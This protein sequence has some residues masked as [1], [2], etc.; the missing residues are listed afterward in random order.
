VKGTCILCKALVSITLNSTC[1]SE[2]LTAYILYSCIRHTL[3]PENV[4][5]YTCKQAVG[6]HNCEALCR[7]KTI[8]GEFA[9][10]GG[11]HV[12]RELPLEASQGRRSTNRKSRF[13]RERYLL[14]G[15]QGEQ[16][17]WIQEEIQDGQGGRRKDPKGP[18]LLSVLSSTGRHQDPG[19]GCGQEER[20]VG[21]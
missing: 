3:Q 9:Q 15:R 4:I 10:H 19:E 16:R 8:S 5:H 11:K 21:P 20:Q 13:T 2:F 6:R 17:P 18:R 12:P 14:K 7:A 1:L